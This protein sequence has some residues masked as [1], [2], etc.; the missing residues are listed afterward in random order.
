MA[1]TTDESKTIDL[2]T[3]MGGTFTQ[4][5]GADA[6]ERRQQRML[7]EISPMAAAVHAG[8]IPCPRSVEDFGE[9]LADADNTSATSH[10]MMNMLTDKNTTVDV[11]ARGG[12]DADAT[13]NDGL[14]VTRRIG[15]YIPRMGMRAIRDAGVHA[16]GLQPETRQ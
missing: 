1:R 7:T 8:E 10:K 16:L 14:N 3:K 11:M 13:I 15:R 4:N 12:S 9:A 6:F 2:A 5:G